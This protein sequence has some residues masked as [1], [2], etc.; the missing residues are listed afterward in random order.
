MKLDSDG[1]VSWSFQDISAAETGEIFM[2]PSFDKENNK[3]FGTTGGLF[4]CFSEEGTKLW[5]IKID[6]EIWTK[7]LIDEDKT[8]YFGTMGDSGKHEFMAVGEGDIIWSIESEATSTGFYSSPALGI[9]NRIL[10]ACHDGYLY[11]VSSETGKKT[12]L[13]TYTKS[14]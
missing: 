14:R 4:Y 12:G 10:V 8:V 2:S 1:T 3:Y 9:S 13:Q 5:S 6:G 11:S 7:P